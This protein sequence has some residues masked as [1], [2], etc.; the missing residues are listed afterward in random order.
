M[1]R[2]RIFM[3]SLLLL[4]AILIAFSS[5]NTEAAAAPQ[6]TGVWS[7]QATRPGSPIARPLIF[8]FHS[9]GTF[10]YSSQTT[11]NGG[12]LA[13]P[14][15]SRAGSNGEWKKIGPSDYAYHSIENMYINGNAGG[16]FY[17]DATVHLNARSGQLCSGRP[18]CPRA[19]TRIRLTQFTFAPDGSIVGETDRLPAG[20]EAVTLCERLSTVFPS[21]P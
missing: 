7:C 13:L 17:V 6:I 12:P 15:T 16:F 3:L 10:S 9:D 21:L 20:S 18:E 11:V 5:G 1:S 4:P 14:F 19:E 2:Y 8:V